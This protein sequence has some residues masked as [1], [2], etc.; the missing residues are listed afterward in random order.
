M[1]SILDLRQDRMRPCL[2]MITEAVIHS[3]NNNGSLRKDIW[4]YIMNKYQDKIDYAEFLIAIR[5]FINEGKMKNK[6][7]FYSMHHAII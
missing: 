4:K 2:Q 6:D 7:G 3:S 5:K 1:A